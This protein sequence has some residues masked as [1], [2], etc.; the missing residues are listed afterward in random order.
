[1]CG[2]LSGPTTRES[3]RR[4]RA[5]DPQLLPNWH[6]KLSLRRV[7]THGCRCRCCY[8][9]ELPSTTGLYSASS[10]NCLLMFKGGPEGP[11]FFLVATVKLHGFY[12]F[13]TPN[14]QFV[15]K[16]DGRCCL[17]EVG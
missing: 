8:L 10:L 3:L 12:P 14:R 17:M 9:W 6:G 11:P 4:P 16:L 13:G 5:P 2:E 7:L 1:M 15:T